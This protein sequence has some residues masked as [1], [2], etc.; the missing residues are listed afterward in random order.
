M[1][2][3]SS[4]TN[5][6][7]IAS[8]LLSVL[9]LGLAFVF[10]NSRASHEVEGDLEDGLKEAAT[11]VDQHRTTRTE[12]VTQMARL[13]AELPTLQAAVD[14][15]DLPTV[16]PVAENIRQQINAD[17]LIVT[18]PKGVVLASAGRDTTALRYQPE[19]PDDGEEFSTLLPH[20]RGVLEVVS[21]PIL[22]FPEPVKLLGRVNVGFFMDDALAHQFKG[23][24]DSEIAFAAGGKVLASSFGRDSYA[25]LEG[26]LAAQLPTPITLKEQEYVALARPMRPGEA[27]AGPVTLTLR[28]RTE[29]MRFLTALRAGLV[30]A[31][32]VAVLL[33]TLLSYAVARTMTRPLAAVTDAMRDVAATGD[34]TR[35]VSVRARAWDDADARLLATAFNTLTDSIGRF[36]REAAQKERLSSL[37]RLST[38]IAHEIRNPLMIIRASL[39]SLRRDQVSASDRLE[40]VADI[41]DETKRLNTLVS[42]VLDFAKPIRFEL[43]P[44]NLNDVCRVSVAAAW[45]GQTEPEVQVDLD[46]SLPSVVTDAERLRTALVNILTNARHAVQ[47]AT[48]AVTAGDVRHPSSTTRRGAGVAVASQPSVFVSTQRHHERAVIVVRDIGIGIG[49]DDLA[50]IFDPYFTT[51]RAGTGLGLPI[52]KNII[53]GL[54]GAIAV[55]SRL[56]HGT[57][58]SIDVPLKE[59]ASP[60]P[61]SGEGG[62][63]H[64]GEYGPA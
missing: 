50:H 40:A 59:P 36:Q 26:M 15:E 16:Q 48:H 27:D 45:A 20:A 8:T 63:P 22:K 56:G 7:F 14:E 3:A 64:R 57:E 37:G 60:K 32:I 53:E 38:V 52:A 12:M 41:D 13:V 28:S 5:R 35:K 51:R 49:A 25:A 34:L 6:I 29:R 55:T 58:I 18:N 10:A 1:R 24:T 23:L 61:H 4:L 54:G 30:A 2:I 39:S 42:D 33:S 19:G 62:K 46:A 17:L 43:A 44:T 47:A 31:L 21:V 11:M 9:S